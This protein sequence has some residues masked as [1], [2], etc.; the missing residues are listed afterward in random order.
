L[1]TSF[2]EFPFI[3]RSLILFPEIILTREL[4][5]YPPFFGSY[6]VQ[7]DFFA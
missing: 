6:Y 7:D 5:N 2:R 1:I 4:S 3:P